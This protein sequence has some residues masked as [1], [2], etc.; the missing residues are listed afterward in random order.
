MLTILQL[1]LKSMHRS[2]QIW[3]VVFLT[4]FFLLLGSVLFA[5]Q[6]HVAWFTGLYWA[7]TTATT[8]GYGDVVPTNTIGRIIAMGTMVTTIP[9]AGYLLSLMASNAT[10]IRLRKVLGLERLEDLRQHVVIVGFNSRAQVVLEELA[11]SGKMQVVVA[12]V[13]STLLPNH[14]R[15]VKGDPTEETTLS[16][17][18]PHK[19]EMAVVTADTD[20]DILLSAIA[21]HH[22]APQLPIIALAK[23]P[24]VAAALED[25]GTSVS[26]SADQL[27]GHTLAKSMEAPHA[28]QLLL[29]LVDCPEHQIQE[30]PV[31]AKQVGQKLSAVR[32][33]P[34]AVVLGLVHESTVRLGLAQ[35]PIIMPGD[36]LLV[37][38]AVDKHPQ[39]NSGPA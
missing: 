20:G 24:K 38:A 13:D 37:M 7:V 23:S 39:K 3:R 36:A 29:K 2:H 10:E 22:L 30:I 11:L 9:L 16:R 35:D 33:M 17:A 34:D 5:W 28:G 1:L 32:D 25:L 27:L 12:N 6:E 31:N 4:L 26:V 8:V 15:L 14:V 18:Q 19:A 21:L